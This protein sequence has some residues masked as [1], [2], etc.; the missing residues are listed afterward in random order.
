MN[1]LL[2]RALRAFTLRTG[3]CCSL[4]RR[5]CRPNGREWADYLSRHGHLHGIGQDCSIQANVVF[6]DPAFV[7]LGNNVHMTG[8]IVFGHD[9]SVAML[10]QAWGVVVDRVGKVEIRDNVFIGHQSIIMPGVTIGPN[11]IV[12][13]G[14]VVTRDVPPGMVVGGVPAKPI[15]TLA[16]YI[17]RLQE[18]MTTLPWRDHP[19]MRGDYIGP[20]DAS[21]EAQRVAH[22]FA[23]SPEGART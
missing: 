22:F 3:R 20:A 16:A 14:S 18:E 7:R 12:A 10:K 2:Q 9:G 19:H 5:L 17:E 21:L 23:S 1:T 15:G 13:A 8:C 6:T 4:Y 11:A